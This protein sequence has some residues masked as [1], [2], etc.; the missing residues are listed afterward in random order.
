MLSPTPSE[1]EVAVVEKNQEEAD[2]EA[3]EEEPEEKPA[4]KPKKKMATVEEVPAEEDT[5]MAEEVVAPTK[6]EIIA[7]KAEA[8]KIAYETTIADITSRG[9]PKK[10]STIIAEVWLDEEKTNVTAALLGEPLQTSR[11][12][13]NRLKKLSDEVL[14]EK[15]AVLYPRVDNLEGKIVRARSEIVHIEN[16][17]IA[18]AY[19]ELSAEKRKKPAPAFIAAEVRSHKMKLPKRVESSDDDSACGCLDEDLESEEEEEEADRKRKKPSAAAKPAAKS[20]KASSS[21]EEEEEEQPK[22]KAKV[23]A[24]KPAKEEPEAKPAKKTEAKP[25]KTDEE[26]KPKKTEEEPKPKKAADD[27]KPKKGDVEAKPKKADAKPK[28]EAKP[29]ASAKN[30]AKPKAEPKEEEEPAEEEDQI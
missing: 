3:E 15:L 14:I 13:F 2:D 25:K 7:S 16:A 6:E 11:K 19:P 24:T 12:A 18:K 22:K 21:S 26:P 9:V 4:K 23:A 29:K 5:V 17:R 27:A 20:K 30:D 8:R 28:G 1:P 10:V